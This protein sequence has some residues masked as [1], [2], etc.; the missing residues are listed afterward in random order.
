MPS[1]SSARP[2][3]ASARAAASAGAASSAATGSRCSSSASTAAPRSL[4]TSTTKRWP[5]SSS[6]VSA[7]SKPAVT[8]G[9]VSIDAQKQLPPARPQFTA[10]KNASRRRAS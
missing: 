1:V 10:T 6:S 8:R 2:I 3:V 5:P 7:R 9:P 4:P